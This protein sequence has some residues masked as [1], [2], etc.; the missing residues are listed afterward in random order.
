MNNTKNGKALLKAKINDLPQD[1][2]R[3]IW[4]YDDTWIRNFDMDV[5]PYLEQSWF[6]KWVKLED[7]K[8]YGDYGIDLTDD[9]MDK[10]S[11]DLH[12]NYLRARKIC[13]KRN[14]LNDG[15]VYIP[16]HNAIGEVDEIHNGGYGK[17]CSRLLS[18][19][20]IIYRIVKPTPENPGTVDN[21]Y[22]EGV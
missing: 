18:K 3:K 8:P 16:S 1:L 19:S 21:I 12:H 11:G 20:C 15:Y 13:D 7:G 17:F 6:I 22:L 5:V 2:Q 9:A 10:E 14:K 4:E